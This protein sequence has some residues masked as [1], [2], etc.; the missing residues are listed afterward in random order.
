MECVFLFDGHVETAGVIKDSFFE[1]T[2]EIVGVG[3]QKSEIAWKMKTK[4][5]WRPTPP[6]TLVL[7]TTAA[8]WAT[9][10]CSCN[11]VSWCAGWM[12]IWFVVRC[13]SGLKKVPYKLLLCVSRTGRCLRRKGQLEHVAPAVLLAV[14]FCGA[15][16]CR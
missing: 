12:V 5:H 3:Y 8:F 10:T 9:I 16:C 4:Y 15:S 6:P 13:C 7:C 11:A 1:N 2:S 14:G